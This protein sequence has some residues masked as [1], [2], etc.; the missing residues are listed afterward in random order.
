MTVLEAIEWLKVLSGSL[1]KVDKRVEALDMGIKALE[2]E[3]EERPT[4]TEGNGELWDRTHRCSVCKG[5]VGIAGVKDTY[6]N[7]CGK[8]VKW[9]E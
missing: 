4:Y 9:G 3:I 6:C 1:C 7:H 8:K 5:I 2:K